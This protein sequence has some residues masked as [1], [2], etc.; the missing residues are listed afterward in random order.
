MRQ[1]RISRRTAVSRRGVLIAGVSAVAAAGLR[2][3]PARA[4]LRSDITAP[5]SR[6]RSRSRSSSRARWATSRWRAR[7][8]VITMQS[9]PAAQP[10]PIDPPPTSSDRRPRR[11]PALPTG[12]PSTPR[13]ASSAARRRP[14]PSS[15]CGRAWPPQEGKYHDAHNI[16]RIGHIISTPST[17]GSPAR[18]A[19]SAAS[20]SSTTPARAS[21]ASAPSL[22][23]QDGVN[24]R[25]SPA[26]RTRA[27]PRS[28]ASQEIISRTGRARPRVY[29]LNIETGQREVV[30]NFPV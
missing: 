19:I 5:C 17:S 10:A 4:A 27:H 12:A 2:V 1:A 23:D 21:A 13:R 25:H 9:R 26:A 29:L 28:P 24:A 11:R 8:Q 6:C 7:T 22:M 15:A 16:R 18:R 30:G 3:A 14:P 20:C